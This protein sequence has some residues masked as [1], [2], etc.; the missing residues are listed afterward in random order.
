M[1]AVDIIQKKKEGCVLSKEEISFLI[2][3]FTQN[4]IPEYQMSAFLMACCFKPLN[5]QETLH[6]TQTILHS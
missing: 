5:F 3:G 1:R 6:L 4:H 2:Q